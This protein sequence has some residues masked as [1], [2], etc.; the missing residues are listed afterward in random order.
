MANAEGR[1]QGIRQTWFVSFSF[2]SLFAIRA[3]VSW[4][5]GRRPP[6][7]RQFGPHRSQKETR[8]SMKLRDGAE[9]FLYLFLYFSFGVSPS[10]WYRLV[11]TQLAKRLRYIE[12]PRKWISNM[13]RRSPLPPPCP[14]VH[15][16]LVDLFRWII[17]C[18]L[19]RFLSDFH[20]KPKRTYC[21][22]FYEYS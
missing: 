1:V 15:L 20:R 5:P 16:L 11:W 13:F 3:T 19:L 12:E 7:R 8:I 9:Y 17:Q 6:H 4:R 18:R 22:H 2:F 10:L 21:C 14:A